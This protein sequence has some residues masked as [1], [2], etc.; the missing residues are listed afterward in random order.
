VVTVTGF[1]VVPAALREAVRA[2]ARALFSVV[3]LPTL[4]AWLTIAASLLHQ[5][6]AAGGT[7]F[8][9]R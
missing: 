3:L 8:W 6:R 2:A 5:H 4:G 1:A 9:N 7:A